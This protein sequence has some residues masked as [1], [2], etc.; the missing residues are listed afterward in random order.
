MRLID[1]DALESEFRRRADTYDKELGGDLFH[2]SEIVAV[3]DNVPTVEYTFE[4][5]FQK[6]VCEQRL[7]CPERPTG[8]WIVGEYMDC[9][10]DILP[11]YTC[12]FC[13]EVAYRKYDFCHCGADMRGGRE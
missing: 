2:I 12:P 1:A 4:E 11:K 6:T 10:S 5:A 8:E 13:G 7:Y 9:R 3:I